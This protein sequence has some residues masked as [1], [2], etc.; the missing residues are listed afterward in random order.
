MHIAICDDNVADRKHLERLL[1]RESDKRAGTPNILYIDSFGDKEHFLRNPLMYD[2]VFMD[3]TSTPTVAAEI[4]HQLMLMGFHAPLVLYSSKIDYTTLSELP[5]TVIH[6]KKPYIP[7]PLP[8]L[9]SLGDSHVRRNI[10]LVSVTCKDGEH[11]V[12][13]ENILYC[14]PSEHGSVLTLQDSA[15]LEILENINAFQVSVLPHQEFCRVSKDLIVNVR[16]ATLITPF[17]IIM[18]NYREFSILPFRYFEL[19]KRRKLTTNK[20]IE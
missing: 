20:K 11:F 16:L 4:I 7:E 18:Q 1:S 19:M 2:M 12:E 13:T 8:E 17:F 3:M 9:L 15:P 5:E 10:V 14:T 6:K